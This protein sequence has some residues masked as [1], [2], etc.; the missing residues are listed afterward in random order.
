MPSPSNLARHL[1]AQFCFGKLAA[2]EVQVYATLAI[3]DHQG[4]PGELVHLAEI[5]TSGKH[6]SHCHRDLERLLRREYPDIPAPIEFRAPARRVKHRADEEPTFET[7]HA[8]HS[9]AAWFHYL[10]ER[11][12]LWFSKRFL[13]CEDGFGNPGRHLSRL[14]RS[15]PDADPRKRHLARTML[16]RPDIVNEAELWKRAVPLVI[17]GD[18][19]PVGK[20]S[21]S[22]VS[23]GGFLC[24]GMSTLDTKMLLSGV[25]SRARC[26][27]TS[28]AVWSAMLWD[29]TTLRA[30]SFPHRDW[31][32]RAFTKGLHYER[33][34]S[35]V[36][37]GLLGV[38]W[39][40]KGDM[41]WLQN[42]LKLE[43]AS[44]VHICP[45][46]LANTI[47][48]EEDEWA[49]VVN[50]APR[51]WND[52]GENAA[53]RRTVWADPAQWLAAHGGAGAVHPLLEVPPGKGAG[54]DQCFVPGCRA[55][56]EGA[57]GSGLT[58]CRRSVPGCRVGVEAA[59]G[60]LPG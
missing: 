39:V 43:G 58:A 40:V 36:A 26:P 10:H 28:A 24:S 5:G 11:K 13:G 3:G 7:N 41:E 48:S 22:V 60:P 55:G 16:E 1:K 54:G 59:S 37:G 42:E 9:A 46:C 18:G 31:E 34:G 52:I 20:Q 25:L 2:A 6:P 27:G 29:L 51:P 8:L 12:P 19:V 53:W 4:S 47:E 15:I 21:L 32:G 50:V 14:W 30:G 23:W 35:A 33:R 56:V 38:I 17:H 44:C 49:S 57:P 45:W